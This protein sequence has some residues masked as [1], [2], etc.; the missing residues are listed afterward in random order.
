[1]TAAPRSVLALGFSLGVLAEWA[2]LR[3]PAFAIPAGS[4][5]RWLAVADFVAGTVLVG[6]G[7]MRWQR[8][9][10]RLLAAA[11][12]A[13]FLGTFAAATTDWIAAAGALF[14]T[15]HRAPF[16]HALLSH[17]SGRMRDPVAIVAVAAA[18]VCAFVADVG[19]EPTAMLALAG[20]V[21][22]AAVRRV[23]TRPVLLGGL[24]YA[25]V[26]VAGASMSG[27]GVLWAY[28]VAV[29]AIAV[30]LTIDL[31]ASET[32]IVVELGEVQEERTL[33]ARLAAA[34]GDPA[35][36]VGYWAPAQ[37]AFVDERGGRV[38]I[39]AD[40]R[41]VTIVRDGGEPVAALVHE[42][43]LL[44]DRRLAESVPAAV[45]IAVANIRLEREI[46]RQ[47]GEVGASRRRLVEAGDVQR[48][49]LEQ[50]VR[51]GAGRRLDGLLAALPA[52]AEAG[53]DPAMVAEVVAEIGAAAGELREFARGV[54]PQ[55][56]TE[57]GL[58]PALA[59]LAGRAGVAAELQLPQARFDPAV[60]AAV[61]FVCA[62]ALA[63]AGKHAP[64]ATVTVAAT[65]D[66]D[67]L[68]VS[69]SD[70]GPGDAALVAGSG[71]RGLA[72]RVEALGGQLS[73][74]SR[75]GAGTTVTAELPLDQGPARRQ[76]C[77]S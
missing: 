33:R 28:D 51:E 43:G 13:W 69:V 65:V 7:A 3:R 12:F 59:D 77:V 39:P 8:R 40:P 25:A 75:A 36:A 63:N 34:L 45:R 67:R 2:A 64:G 22:L 10:G 68:T 50:R 32:Q 56:L 35:L 49:Q 57:G 72:D 37:G 29:A 6:C 4:A 19:Q 62:E 5:E 17:P 26:L 47:I 20:L 52:A 23:A 66:A 73:V 38:D 30:A 21:A 42:P 31:R 1:M 44:D 18:Y 61:Y 76:G 46:A 60:E 27:D 70:D 15:L 54:H 74:V 24:A 58:E 53:A 41:R 11:G 71:L 9:S 16:V 48:R 55:L 14:L